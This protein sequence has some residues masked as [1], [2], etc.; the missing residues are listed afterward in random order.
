MRT[1]SEVM[2][3]THSQ[4]K[5]HHI[6]QRVVYYTGQVWGLLK[7]E[8]S[9]QRNLLLH[10]HTVYVCCLDILIYPDV[11]DA[12]MLALH[13]NVAGDGHLRTIYKL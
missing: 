7:H 9:L 3:L 11:C 10:L 13:C 8:L 6:A 4:D 12:Y 1:P 5:G 2:L